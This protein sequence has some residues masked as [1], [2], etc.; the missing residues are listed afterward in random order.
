[1]R[2]P[3]NF[4]R[5]RVFSEFKIIKRLIP[6]IKRHRLA[7]TAIIVMGCLIALSEG[8]GIS[9]FIPLLYS[10]NADEFKPETDDWIGRLLNRF[11]E[12]TPPTNRLIYISFLIFGFV[13]LRGLLLYGSNILSAWLNARLSHFLRCSAYDQL[14]DVG[15]RFIDQKPSGKLMNTL[16]NETYAASDAVDM[17]IAL[18]IKVF[19]V[20]I[21]TVFLLLISWR[22]TILVITVLVIISLLIKTMTR[23]VELLSRE[24]LKADEAFLQ[25]IIDF[26]RGVRTIRACGRELYERQRFARASRR[27]SKVNIKF[28]INSGFIEPLSEVL[29]VTLIVFILFFAIPYS[30]NLP[31]VLVFIFLLYRLRPYFGELDETRTALVGSIASVEAVTGLLEREDKPYIQTGSVPFVGLRESIKFDSVCFQY[32]PSKK[33]ALQDLSI[34]IPKGK[35]TAIVGPSGAGKSTLIHLLIRFYEPCDGTIYVDSLPLEKLNLDSW[36]KRL[37]VVC[38]EEYI[39]NSTVRQNIAYGRMD[40]EDNEI[41]AAAELALAHSFI[42][43]LPEGYDTILGERGVRLSAGQK[44]RISLSRAIVRHP[45][46]LLLDEAT[47][48]LDSI[49][50][51]QIQEN[52]K[53]L[54]EEMHHYRRGTPAVLD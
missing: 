11:F 14:L 21:L 9:L 16:E 44:Q 43:A 19:T 38:Q 22:L 27:I 13:F 40:A 26:F 33:L 28:E 50:E 20:M 5:R 18:V 23:R 54:P 35:T 47:N 42:R 15:M 52:L 36:R 6:L 25:R 3:Q 51:S 10:L 2:S 46:I 45:E 31:T 24:G 32:E 29:A 30:F 17:V 37:A 49:S 1:M 34:Q 48:A 53:H 39:F 8:I 12:M 7:V 41:I 4:Y